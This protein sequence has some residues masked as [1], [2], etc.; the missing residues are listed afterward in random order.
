MAISYSLSSSS[1][2][3]AS[4]HTPSPRE[5]ERMSVQADLGPWPL[6]DT[7][8]NYDTSCHR[9]PM[10]GEGV[11]RLWAAT[12]ALAAHQVSSADIAIFS[13]QWS[14]WSHEGHA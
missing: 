1:S 12:N 11:K 2:A 8:L 3:G 5:G 6:H 9:H 14:E 4:L 10:D 7:Q 13:S